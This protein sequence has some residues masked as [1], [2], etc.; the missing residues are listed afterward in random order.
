V[1]KAGSNI[2]I[3]ASSGYGTF[4]FPVL[5]KDSYSGLETTIY[6]KLYNCMPSSMTL[7]PDPTTVSVLGP[8]QNVSFK[9]FWGADEDPYHR[10]GIWAAFVQYDQLNL[11][12]TLNIEQRSIIFSA[13][14]GSPT[15]SYDY[16]VSLIR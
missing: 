14:F 13:P 5:V 3:A 15:K 9:P 10:C 1:T 7:D 16:T 6:V 2:N 11:F 12:M 8:A 4:S